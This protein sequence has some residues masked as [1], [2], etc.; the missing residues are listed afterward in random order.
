MAATQDSMVAGLFTTPEQYQEQQR[1]ALY[2]QAVQEARLDPYQQARVSLQ[3]G[4]QGLA[5]AGA[6]MLGVEDPQMKA[7]SVLQ[8]LSGKYDTNTSGGVAALAS[9]LQKRGMQQQ[10]MI[11]GQR[12][13]E[14]RKTEAEAQAKTAEKL[15]N[16]QKN[17]AAGADASGAERGTPEWNNTYKTELAR[18]TAGSTSGNIKE[19]GIAKSTGKAV[20]FDVGTG[21]QFIVKQDPKDPTKQIRVPFDG[22]VDRTTSNVT[23]PEIKIPADVNALISSYEKAVESDV[24][25]K[26]L[27]G[28]AKGLINQAATSNNPSAWEAART[29]TAK[30]VGQGKLSNED[31]AR[32]GIDPTL[33][34]GVRDW[35][36]KKTVGVPDANTQ[37]ALF[38][39]ASY[40][41]K[42]ASGRIAEK[43]N[44]RIA[45]AKG[46]NPNIDTGMMFPDYS[47]TGQTNVGAGAGG[48]GK[49]VDFKDFGKKVTP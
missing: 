47:G 9:E 25:V 21:T 17:A 28:T 27:A 31:I 18:L 45:A 23:M 2:N 49:I 32:I 42:T 8:E 33:I 36:E 19:I 22:S 12:A 20:Y 7:R 26:N 43:R 15:T 3:T 11:L 41:E 10:A 38:A 40:L 44:S 1:Q 48:G 16:E 35:I 24:E 46:I 5:N 13:L 37:K 29:Q 34:G 4:V 39:V 14:M 6:G 30:A